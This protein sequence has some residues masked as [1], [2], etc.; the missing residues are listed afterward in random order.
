MRGSTMVLVT[1]V[2]G[3]RALGDRVTAAAPAVALTPRDLAGWWLAIDGVFPALQDKSG[4][5]LE[6]LLIMTADGAVDDRA[7]SFRHASAFV[8]AK[9]KLCSDAPLMARARLTIDG[10]KL[11][12]AERTPADGVAPELAAAALTA[13]PSWTVA[14]S[15][16]NAL[17]TSRADGVSR[18]FARIDPDPQN[19]RRAGVPPPSEGVPVVH[20]RRVHVALR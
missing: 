2:V 4:S 6:E 13:T 9:S 1:E 20:V 5:V 7:M 18:S 3:V 17:L 19:D 16:G 8:C 12:F 11:A 10:D 15:A 14:L